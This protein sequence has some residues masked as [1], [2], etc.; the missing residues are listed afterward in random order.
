MARPKILRAEKPFLLSRPRQA[1]RRWLRNIRRFLFGAAAGRLFASKGFHGLPGSV[2]DH[3]LRRDFTGL[4][5]AAR[6]AWKLMVNRATAAAGMPAPRK[7]HHW[8]EMR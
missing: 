7:T 2:Q 1:I 3:S 4:E 6:T 5:I 8:M